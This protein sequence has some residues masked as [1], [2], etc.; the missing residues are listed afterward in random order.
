LTEN[1]ALDLFLV[2]LARV[3]EEQRQPKPWLNWTSEA[4]GKGIPED[5]AGRVLAKLRAEKAV[6]EAMGGVVRFSASG[7]QTYSDRVTAL[8]QLG[9]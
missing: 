4:A 5:I 8:R 3:Y 1:E 7:Y 9:K 2:A 6:E